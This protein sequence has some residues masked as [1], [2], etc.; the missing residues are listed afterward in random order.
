MSEASGAQGAMDA[1]GRALGTTDPALAMERLAALTGVPRSLGEA[2]FS[3]SDADVAL[4]VESVLGQA[5]PSIRALDARSLTALLVVASAVPTSVKNMTADS[6]TLRAPATL[7]HQPGFGSTHESEALEGALPRQQNAPWP[8]PYGLYPELLNGTPF[9]VKNAQNSRVWMYRVRASFSHTPYRELASSGFTSELT[10]V[11]PNRT[12]WTPLPIPEATRRVDFLDGLV[13]LGG[14]GDSTG[15]GYLVHL[16]AANA[17]MADRAFSSADG[18][19]LIVPQSGV[20]DVRTELGFLR[21][22][23]GSILVIPRAIKFA[24]GVRDK[25]ARGWML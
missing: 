2:G 6:S 10:N 4:V 15:P 22:A 7:A 21:V 9:T 20:L 23:P 13:T 8:A 24:I 19:I 17:D 14:D 1:I 11:E 25:S 5:P 3:G 16:Y 12:R 18:D